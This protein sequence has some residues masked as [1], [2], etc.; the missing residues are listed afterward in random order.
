MRTTEGSVVETRTL[1]EFRQKFN[2]EESELFSTNSWTWSLRPGQPTLGAGVLSLRRYALR[3]SDIT[4]PEG[5]ELAEIVGVIERTVQKC[6]DYQIMNYLM[7]MMV[8]HHVHYH[9]IPRY[10]ST[11]NFASKEWVDTGWP[12]LPS[13]GDDQHADD[14]QAR[15]MM[16]DYLRSELQT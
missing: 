14:R 3:L 10:S 2:V 15:A 7:L 13:M 12:A 9:V 6:F 8:D 16:R 4:G 1:E 11:K 5:Q